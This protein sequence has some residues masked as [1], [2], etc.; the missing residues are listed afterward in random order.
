MG[1]LRHADTPFSP[2]LLI[3]KARFNPS[4]AQSQTSL[5]ANPSQALLEDS[6]D[7]G[8]NGCRGTQT[9]T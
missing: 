3:M 4:Q 9:F 7:K 2:Q 1:E 6:R 8:Q 5:F